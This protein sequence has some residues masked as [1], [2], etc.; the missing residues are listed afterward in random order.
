M[1]LSQLDRPHTWEQYMP[2]LLRLVVNNDRPGVGFLPPAIVVGRHLVPLHRA[3]GEDDTSYLKRLASEALCEI[4]VSPLSPE[5]PNAKMVLALFQRHPSDI[6]SFKKAEV[7]WSKVAKSMGGG[8][9]LSSYSF[10]IYFSYKETRLREVILSD[11][12]QLHRV[13]EVRAFLQA[14]VSS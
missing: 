1:L 3:I 9:F 5:R 4:R 8:T 12:C 14:I 7:F 6:D 10:F 11:N 2:P 13:Q